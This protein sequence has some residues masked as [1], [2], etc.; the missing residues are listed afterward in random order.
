M[1]TRAVVFAL[2]ATDSARVLAREDDDALIGV[3]AEI[4]E[5]RDT[6]RLCEPDSPW[7]AP[8]RYLTDGE[9]ALGNGDFPCRTPSSAGYRSTRVAAA[10]SATSPRSRSRGDVALEPLDGEWLRE[11]YA[12]LTFDAHQG[13]A[14]AEDVACTQAFLPGL[15]RFHGAAF[16]EG[17]AV[18]F[19]VGQ[20]AARGTALARPHPRDGRAR[21]G[22]DRVVGDIPAAEA[23]RDVPLHRLD[24]APGG[25]PRAV[26]ADRRGDGPGPDRHFGGR[27]RPSTTA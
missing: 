2:D 19:T 18:I 13:T 26:R 5:H 22:E 11:R 3:A 12:T 20:Q 6:D 23:P 10:S 4:E 9:P 14:D 24:Q 27:S 1:G 17:R 21:A 15:K 16:R 8:H 7:D 25:G